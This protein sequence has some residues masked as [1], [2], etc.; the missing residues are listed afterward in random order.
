MRRAPACSSRPVAAAIQALSPTLGEHDALEL[1]A[2]GLSLGPDD[3]IERLTEFGYTRADVVEHRG[4]FAVRGGLVDV[5]A[6]TAR[7][8]VRV[9]YW[10]DQIESLRSSRR[11]RS[12][13]PGRP[14]A[15]RSTRAAS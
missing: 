1:T 11:V 2:G 10:G 12:S 13:R 7:R 6:S 9:D 4:E 5:F 14:N 8:P 3:L 15:S